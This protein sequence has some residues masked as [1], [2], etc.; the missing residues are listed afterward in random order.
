M[1]NF[2]HGKNGA[3]L[4]YFIF[5]IS[6]FHH[7]KLSLDFFTLWMPWQRDELADPWIAHGHG[8]LCSGT[9]MI[10]AMLPNLMSK[11]RGS[12]DYVYVPPN[13]MPFPAM[14]VTGLWMYTFALR[15]PMIVSCFG[16]AMVCGQHS[17]WK[18]FVKAEFTK[19]D[20]GAEIWKPSKFVNLQ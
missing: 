8:P 17:Q 7:I 19:S 3:W 4:E 2:V 5:N 18:R 10:S 14:L 11:K 12:L 16:D 20:C 9:M 13:C 1:V 15:Y 6:H